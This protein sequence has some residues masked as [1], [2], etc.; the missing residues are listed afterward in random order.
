VGAAAD[1]AMNVPGRQP[2]AQTLRKEV[3]ELGLTFRVADIEG[4]RRDDVP[5]LFVLQ[6]NVADLRPV[7]VGEDEIVARLD[8]LRE[9]RAG[10]L[11]PPS[12]TRGVRGLTGGLQRIAANR[13]DDLLH[14]RP[15]AGRPALFCRFYKNVRPCKLE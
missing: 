2:V 10:G 4:H 13:D 9:A 1:A 12:L 5:T 15:P 3:A 6:Q 8:D 11:D 7:P 14:R